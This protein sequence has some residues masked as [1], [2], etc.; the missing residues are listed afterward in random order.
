MV[1][2]ISTN[3]YDKSK[4]EPIYEDS[5]K[6]LREVYKPKEDV[7]FEPLN[8]LRKEI[9]VVKCGDLEV[10]T[11]R[12]HY[13]EQRVHILGLGVLDNYRR[14]GVCSMMIDFLKTKAI[15]SNLSQ[16]SLYTIRETGN[17]EVFRKS[18]FE[19]SVEQVTKDFVSEKY[20]ELHEV[21][22]VLN[23]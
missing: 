1:E 4:L 10:G 3:S 22:M 17:V 5:R 2:I 11:T 16:I 6:A 18:G 8:P 23:L 7:V 15:K 9:I 13:Y 19:V 21:Y 14:K 20:N 12:V